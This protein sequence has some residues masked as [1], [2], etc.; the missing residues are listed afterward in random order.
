MSLISIV[1]PVY[2]EAN[3]L[4]TL[5]TRLFDIEKN[6]EEKLEYIFV[7]D[8]S[9][10]ETLKILQTLE[11]RKENVRYLS[12]SRNFGHEAA[13]TAG[14]DHADGNAIVVIDADLQDP[15]E[16]IPELVKKWKEDFQIVFAQRRTR[17]GEKKL[18]ILTS[19]IFYRVFKVIS[20]IEMPVDT[21]DFRLIDRCVAEQLKRCREENRFIRGLISWTGFKQCAVLYDRDG[22]FSGKSNYNLL[23]RSLLAM[24][25]FLGFSTI[26][27]RIVLFLGMIVCFFS[28]IMLAITVIQKIFFD[29]PMKGYAL[30]TSAIFF[31]SGVQLFVMG[32]IGEY[33]GRIYTH[34]QNRP[35]YIIAEQSKSFQKFC[36]KTDI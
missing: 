12:F 13:T 22:R 15:P 16:L 27:L 9:H 7:N 10:D 33:V 17:S 28:I 23:K 8:G 21:G 35:L 36:C 19:W 6:I 34:S 32:L 1:I 14:I 29:M 2:N 25:A 11:K 30:L 18:T 4:E 20:H 5:A 31:F 26:P 3:C 24:D